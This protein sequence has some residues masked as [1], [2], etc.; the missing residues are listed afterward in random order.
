[1]TNYSPQNIVSILD[2]RAAELEDIADNLAVEAAGVSMALKELRKSLEEI[3]EHLT[4]REFEKA[5]EAGYGELARNFVYVQRTLAGL[6]TA[7]PPRISR[8]PV[9]LSQAARAHS[10]CWR[11]Y[12]ASN[13]AGGR[14]PMGSNSRR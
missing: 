7:E 8:R 13:S 10:R 14:C 12:A 6:Q 11:S 5:S 9:K 4:K 2:G 3:A 1:M